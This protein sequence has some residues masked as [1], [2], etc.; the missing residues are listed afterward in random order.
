[1][2]NSRLKNPFQGFKDWRIIAEPFV[3]FNSLSA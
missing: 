2:T 1:L 3:P